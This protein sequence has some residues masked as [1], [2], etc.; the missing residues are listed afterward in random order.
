MAL[1]LAATDN[2]PQRPQDGIP[3]SHTV[4]AG[5]L[6]VMRH[7]LWVKFPCVLIF[8]IKPPPFFAIFSFNPFN[9]FFLF[10]L[11]EQVRAASA[12]TGSGGKKLKLFTLL[13]WKERKKKHFLEILIVSEKNLQVNKAS[14][15]DF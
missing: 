14:T 11:H 7:M 3:S 2:N 15:F 10:V 4:K 13:R 12:K 8:M 1:I 6:L 9:P 5:A